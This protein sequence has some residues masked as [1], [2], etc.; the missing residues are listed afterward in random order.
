MVDNT[1][2]AVAAAADI[3]AV[4]ILAAEVDGSRLAGLFRNM[5]HLD[6]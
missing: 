2:P 3:L 4:D 5:L 6:E 1:Y